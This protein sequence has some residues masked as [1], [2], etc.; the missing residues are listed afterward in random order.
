VLATTSGRFGELIGQPIEWICI[1]SKAKSIM[2][3][4]FLLA[5]VGEQVPLCPESSRLGAASELCSLTER[6]LAVPYSLAKRLLLGVQWAPHRF[7]RPAAAARILRAAQSIPSRRIET[8]EKP[9][10]TPL[11]FYLLVP[12]RS[13]TSASVPSGTWNT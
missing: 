10:W 8:W 3:E 5:V 2:V 7:D 6:Q 9:F 13:L 1:H 12:R 11:L 4:A